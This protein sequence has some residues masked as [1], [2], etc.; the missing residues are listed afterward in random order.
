MACVYGSGKKLDE[1][2]GPRKLAS[3]RNWLLV[4]VEQF[5]LLSPRKGDVRAY[6]EGPI[7]T[8]GY[9]FRASFNLRILLERK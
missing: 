6:F 4:G 2:A 7:Q 1:L 3:P 9:D 5:N 8:L